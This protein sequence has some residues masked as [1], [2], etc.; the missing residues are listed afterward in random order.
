MHPGKAASTTWC[1]TQAAI[2]RTEP[3]ATASSKV[4]KPR[5]NTS[6]KKLGLYH[7]SRRAPWRV[8]H[9]FPS[10]SN[11]WYYCGPGLSPRRTL[12]KPRYTQVLPRGTSDGVHTSVS[13]ITVTC[14]VRNNRIICQSSDP[15]GGMAITLNQWILLTARAIQSAAVAPNARR[16]TRLPS[17][18]VPDLAR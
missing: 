13:R 2:A 6:N 12:G 18:Q 5:R 15:L 11:A 16:G 4:Q 14:R 7:V 3:A 1:C 8:R 17:S 10:E 9:H